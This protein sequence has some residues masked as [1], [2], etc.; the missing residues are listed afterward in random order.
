MNARSGPTGSKALRRA[1]EGRRDGRG[2]D[3]DS[4]DVPGNR[5]ARLRAVRRGAPG[6]GPKGKG[7]RGSGWYAMQPRD[8]DGGKLLRAERLRGLRFRE[9]GVGPVSTAPAKYAQWAYPGKEGILWK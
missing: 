2:S 1:R 5:I 7:A 8:A 3:A 6:F 9:K 4:V